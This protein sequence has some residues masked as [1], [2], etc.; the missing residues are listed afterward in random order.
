[1][2]LGTYAFDL[3]EAAA[4]CAVMPF[5]LLVLSRFHSNFTQ[6]YLGFHSAEKR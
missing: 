2:K 1:M 4:Q 6:T 5:S 3:V